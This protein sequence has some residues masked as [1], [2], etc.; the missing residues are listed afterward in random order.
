MMWYGLPNLRKVRAHISNTKVREN[1]RKLLG[2]RPELSPVK[3][4]HKPCLKEITLL[5]L[6]H[7]IVIKNTTQLT[8]PILVYTY[9]DVY[10][11]NLLLT[12]KLK[13][14]SFEIQ[15]SSF[16]F[17]DHILV[18]QWV[19]YVR[20]FAT[21]LT[22][23]TSPYFLKLRFRGKGYYLYK[24]FR[25]VVTP[26]FGYSHRRYLYAYFTSIVFL[27]KTKILVFGLSVR[28]VT[29]LGNMLQTIRSANIFTGRG[30]RL[31][32]QIFYRK[33]GKVSTYR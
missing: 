20:Q 12:F 16:R 3:S 30:M 26:Q 33:T 4:Y 13:D 23:F 19:F 25:Q 1:S 2:S 17:N 15:T 22:R 29:V 28:Q 21:L 7:F 31:A 10:F 9:S 14:H 11:I 24:N 6:F 27:T 8:H 18:P 5:S 32:R